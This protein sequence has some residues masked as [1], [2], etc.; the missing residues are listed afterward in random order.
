[1]N[2]GT[3]EDTSGANTSRAGQFSL[4]ASLHSTIISKVSHSEDANEYIEVL[5]KISS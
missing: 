2:N 3:P 5:G 4:N 1:M